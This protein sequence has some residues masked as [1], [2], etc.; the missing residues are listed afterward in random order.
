LCRCAGGGYQGGGE[1]GL[2]EW[3]QVF[4]GSH[5]SSSDEL[6]LRIIGVQATA[7]CQGSRAA[8]GAD[9]GQIEEDHASHAELD[10]LRGDLGCR[11]SLPWS[12]SL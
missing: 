9:G 3:L 5:A 4:R 2:D 8:G 7:E 10:D 1:A 12:M 11:N 6:H